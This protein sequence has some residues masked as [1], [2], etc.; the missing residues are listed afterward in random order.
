MHFWTWIVSDTEFSVIRKK[1]VRHDL[2]SNC[3]EHVSKPFIHR[4]VVSAVRK[5][6]KD[7][8]N[9]GCLWAHFCFHTNFLVQNGPRMVVVMMIML[10]LLMLML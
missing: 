9:S 8:E 6:T 5:L 3:M 10:L 2:S 4:Y 1:H 7:M